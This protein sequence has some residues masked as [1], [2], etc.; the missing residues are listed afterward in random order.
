MSTVLE[1]T[2]K[3]LDRKAAP[4]SNGPA[5]IVIFPG[6]RFERL[7]AEPIGAAFEPLLVQR[8]MTRS[9]QAIAEDLQS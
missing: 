5:K 7:E 4:S 6:V 2:L 9:S 3:K 1:F 8:L